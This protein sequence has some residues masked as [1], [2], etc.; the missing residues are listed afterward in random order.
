MRNRITAFALMTQVRGAG[1]A[2]HRRRRVCAAILR[3]AGHIS[4]DCVEA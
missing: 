2:H 4:L 1:F 3:Q